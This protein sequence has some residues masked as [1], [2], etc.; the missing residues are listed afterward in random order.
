[1]IEL[2]QVPRTCQGN[3]CVTFVYGMLKHEETANEER[4]DYDGIFIKDMLVPL[5]NADAEA[6]YRRLIPLEQQVQLHLDH[7]ANPE[8]EGLYYMC[9]HWDEQTRLCTA[10]NSRPR[11][12]SDYP[13]GRPC[14]HNCGYTRARGLSYM[15]ARRHAAEEG[16]HLGIA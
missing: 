3:C 5:S 15:A 4:S 12:C 11:M 13:Y 14:E 8:N 10:Y 1:M 16:V 2:Q 7:F 9:R 6:R